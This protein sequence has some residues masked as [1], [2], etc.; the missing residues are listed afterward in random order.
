MISV[1]EEVKKKLQFDMNEAV[2]QQKLISTNEINE[3]K[4]SSFNLRNELENLRYEFYV[5]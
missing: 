2:Q 3:L 5:P 4:N 1:G